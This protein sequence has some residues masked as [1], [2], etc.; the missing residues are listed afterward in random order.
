MSLNE[1]LTKG[2]KKLQLTAIKENFEEFSRQATKE[3][4]IYEQYLNLLVELEIEK[5]Q[6]NKIARYLKESKLPLEKTFDQFDKSKLPAKVKQQ[7]NQLLEG[8]FVDH[9][10]NILAFG[11][12]GGGK[13]HLLCAI[14]HHL[15]RTQ[16]RRVLFTT[17]SDIVEKLLTAKKELNM[18]KLI[19]KLSKYEIIIIDDIGYVE[20]TREEMSVLFTLLAER[21]ERGSLLISSNLPF[22]KWE[23]IFKDPMT[24]AAAIDRLVHHSTILDLNIESYRMNAAKEKSKKGGDSPAKNNKG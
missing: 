19:K 3:S 15:I 5:R 9:R 2:L 16:E 17:C 22:S 4:L 14:G 6:Q 20:Q 13:T 10:E 21:Y 18:I 12:P 8:H 1:T 7:L 23:Q 11:T 24:T